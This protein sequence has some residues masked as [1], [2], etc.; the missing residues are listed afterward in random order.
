MGPDEAM[1]RQHLEDDAFLAG[2]ARGKW[3]LHGGVEAIAWPNLVFWMRSSERY[4]PDKGVFLQFDLQ[5]YPQQ[6]PT[7]CPWDAEKNV[8]LDPG[9]WPKGPGNVSRVFKPGWNG[10]AAL[11]A[12]CDR[13]AMPQHEGWIIQHPRWWWKSSFT[14]LRYLE[15]VYECLNPC[16]VE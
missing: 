6:A 3:K 14:F 16:N 5:N 1:F 2:V 13:L 4:T 8:R 12:P 11:Y 9:R 7:S 15:F 10:A